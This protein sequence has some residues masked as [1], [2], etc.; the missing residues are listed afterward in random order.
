M[1]WWRRIRRY[2]MDR[3]QTQRQR[4][5]QEEA[6]RKARRV[7]RAYKAVFGSDDQRTDDQRIV[8]EDMM[9]RFGARSPAFMVTPDGTCDPYLAAIRDGKRSVVMEVDSILRAKSD[10]DNETKVQVQK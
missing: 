6:A 5:A 3:L 9:Q 8:Y 7:V 1:K 10:E 4:E 2:V